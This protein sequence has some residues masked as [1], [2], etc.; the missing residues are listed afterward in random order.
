MIKIE[1]K[2]LSNQSNVTLSS[3]MFFFPAGAAQNLLENKAFSSGL[4]NYKKDVQYIL[5]VVRHMSKLPTHM[6]V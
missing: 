2:F 4:K 3:L 1:N 6:P 5:Y